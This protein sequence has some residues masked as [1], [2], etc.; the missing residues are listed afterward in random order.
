VSM[1]VGGKKR[2]WLTRMGHY[3]FVYART[4]PPSN[5]LIW[6]SHQRRNYMSV[7]RVSAREGDECGWTADLD[8]GV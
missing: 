5:C 3:L 1:V 8:H 4:Q 2:M 6:E 7:E